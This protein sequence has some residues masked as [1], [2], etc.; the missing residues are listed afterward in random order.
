M[1]HLLDFK[2]LNNNLNSLK[3]KELK[4]IIIFGE[5]NHFQTNYSE[6][7]TFMDDIELEEN[8]LTD[9]PLY[10]DSLNKTDSVFSA[11]KENN[12]VLISKEQTQINTQS[13]IDTGGGK[14]PP[15][16]IVG[17]AASFSDSNGKKSF[18]IIDKKRREIVSDYSDNK[19]AIIS[20]IAIGSLFIE[21]GRLFIKPF[22]I[23]GLCQNNSDLK[24]GENG[25]E[26]VY[27]SHTNGL[28]DGNECP[29]DRSEESCGQVDFDDFDL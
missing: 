5:K 23:D 16:R 24:E 27:D 17:L 28:L 22:P 18:L 10:D 2:E 12:K 29:L 14:F 19:T 25:S 15:Y 4:Y 13:Q 8:N 1:L 21:K 11:R 3:S 20:G 6:K 7:L 26:Y 9:Q